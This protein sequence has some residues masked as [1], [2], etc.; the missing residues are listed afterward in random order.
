MNILVSGIASDIGYNAGKIIKELKISTQ[1]YGMDIL[2]K[3]YSTNIFDNQLIAS[4]ANNEFYIN[5]LS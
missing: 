2:N 1:L 3:I 5:W 4:K